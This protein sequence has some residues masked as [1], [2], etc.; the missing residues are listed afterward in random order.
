MEKGWFVLFAVASIIVLPL[1]C[2]SGLILKLARAVGFDRIAPA[3]SFTD[4]HVD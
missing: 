3:R 4:D 2:G 1:V